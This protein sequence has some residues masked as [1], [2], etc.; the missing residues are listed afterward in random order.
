ML[1]NSPYLCFSNGLHRNT[2]SYYFGGIFY[3][4]PPPIRRLLPKHWI[5]VLCDSL[6]NRV[7]ASFLLRLPET[8]L[9]SINPL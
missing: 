7:M 8:F 2:S 4:L 3:S 5:S 1:N 6:L 9:T